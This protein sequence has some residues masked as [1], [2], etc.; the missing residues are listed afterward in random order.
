MTDYEVIRGLRRDSQIVWVPAHKCL[1]VK[2]ESR[3]GFH[4]YICYQTI[5]CDP[6]KK[7][8]A[9]VIPCTCRIKIDISTGNLLPSKKQHSSHANH[10]LLF[11]DMNSKN[12]ITDDVVAITEACKG[13]A[14]HVPINDIFTREIAT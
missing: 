7:D 12:K 6:K 10:E 5:L 8:V 3:G 11:K 9:S 4:E 14:V 13:L 2:K 1:Y